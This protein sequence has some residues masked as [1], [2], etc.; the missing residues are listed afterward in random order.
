M[1]ITI[2]VTAIAII[3]TI[4]TSML[5]VAFFQ[6]RRS[7]QLLQAD[8][9]T[10]SLETNQLLT[11]VHQ[12]VQNDLHAVTQQTTQLISNLSHLSSPDLLLNSSSFSCETIPQIMKW[13]GRSVFLLKTIREV[14]KK[15]E[16]RTS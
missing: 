1:L 7:L 11:R 4:L 14:I 5:I 8:V 3:L 16:T 12:Y 2:S 10:L 9:H 15:H 13:I 6:M